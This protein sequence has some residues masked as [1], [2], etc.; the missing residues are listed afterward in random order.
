MSQPQDMILFTIGPVQ[1]FIAAARRTQDLAAGSRL[2]SWLSQKGLEFASRQGAMIVYPRLNPAAGANLPNRLVL[3]APE[4]RGVKL[5]D[6]LQCEIQRL[7]IE[8]LGGKIKAELNP[9]V[10]LWDAAAA[11]QMEQALEIYW[12]VKPWDGQDSTYLP[13]YREA[14]LGLN[15]RKSLRA[16][17]FSPQPGVKCTLCGI[18][19]ALNKTDPKT[20][21]ETLSGQYGSR[22]LRENERLCAVCAAKRL[23]Y[24]AG[25]KP[26][27]GVAHFPSTS[28]IAV[29]S[30]RAAVEDNWA[31]LQEPALAFLQALQDIKLIEEDRKL[32][33]STF[34]SLDGDLFFKDFYRRAERVAEI[35]AAA[36][37][38]DDQDKIVGCLQGLVDALAEKKL[39]S[40][41]IPYYAILVIDGDKMGELLDDPASAYTGSP[42]AQ[43]EQHERISV[44]LD[45]VAGRMAN[46]ARQ[47][48]QATVIF[49]GGDDALFFLSAD[50]LLPAADYLRQVFAEELARE[51]FPGRHASAGAAIVHHQAPLGRSLVAARNAEAEAKDQY[52]RDALAV[53]LLRRSGE[54]HQARLHWNQD[55]LGGLGEFR[56]LVAQGL[57]SGALAYEFQDEAVV[58]PDRAIELEL[59]RLLERHRAS[60]LSTAQAAS[61]ADRLLTGMNGISLLPG[62]SRAAQLAEWL[63]IMRFLA[64]GE[65]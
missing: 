33:Q 44:A 63:L 49:S 17:P 2:L 50:T 19:S 21:W 9:V 56:Q 60:A 5:A 58:L 62:V 18:R 7:W 25:F 27:A 29:A 13:A 43:K 59:K 30:F 65:Q 55:L 31:V 52:D 48:F 26:L 37:S 3:L 42:V 36:L 45:R 40:S 47:K 38:K 14:S 32:D 51:G 34:H 61:L 11:A 1:S 20:D 64:K 39:G 22:I 57:I 10:Q 4:G 35:N 16:Y 12:A 23:G 8:D 15:A 41:P 46:E 24:V 54:P 28:D 6:D 53:W